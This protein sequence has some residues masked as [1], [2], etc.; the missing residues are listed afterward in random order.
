MICSSASPSSVSHEHR[1]CAGIF[2]LSP[3]SESSLHT[4]SS[5]C[6]LCSRSNLFNM[7]KFD[8]SALVN[9]LNQIDIS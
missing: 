3:T 4:V 1:N 5:W 6:R 8:R 9:C 2:V 7:V